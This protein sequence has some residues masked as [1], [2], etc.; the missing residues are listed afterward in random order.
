MRITSSSP[1]FFVNDLLKSVRYYVD[2]LGFNEPELWGEPASFAMPSK[3]GFIIMLNQA[4]TKTPTPNGVG[5]CWDAYFWCDGVDD[6]Y[7]GLIERGADIVHPPEVQ[8]S[9]GMKE[10]GV[11]DPDG[12]TLVFAEDI[13]S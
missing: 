4:D 5:D 13:E 3:D 8:A 1:H 9:Y 2:V 10:L 11:K 6:Y 7:A 12:Y